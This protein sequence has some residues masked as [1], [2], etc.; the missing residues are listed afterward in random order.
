[1][2]VASYVTYISPF[3]STKVNIQKDESAEKK[4]ANFSF[5]HNK[6][7]TDSLKTIPFTPKKAYLPSYNFLR[8]QQAN[9]ELESFEK[10]KKYQDAK[11]AYKENSTLYSLAQRPK[12]VIGGTKPNLQIS[13]EAQEAKQTL[14]KKEMVNIYTQNENYYRITAA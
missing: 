9:Q 8:Q 13:K 6:Q 2:Y 10:I 1:M 11:L 7:T 4:G 14:A 5:Q 3:Q 12:S